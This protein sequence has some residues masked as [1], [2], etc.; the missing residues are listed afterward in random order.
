MALLGWGGVGG[1][2]GQTSSDGLGQGAA[3][4]AQERPAYQLLTDLIA[5]NPVKEE[6]A[7][8][9]VNPAGFREYVA[10]VREVWQRYEREHLQPIREWA[11]QELRAE[12]AATVFYPFSGP[13]LANML[14]FFPDART[15]VMLALE[16]VGS[17]PVL[18]PGANEPFYQSL[19]YAL[20]ELLHFN[21][22]MTEHL[23]NDLRQRE[24]DGVLPL[25]LFF[26]G[27]EQV[28]V[29]EVSFLRQAPAG[30]MLAQPARPGENFLGPGVPGVKIVFQRGP[31]APAQTL[32]Y[33]SFNLQNASWR[34]SPQF[35]AWL[36]SLGPL[37]TMVKAASYLMFKSLYSD[38][39]QFILDRSQLVLQTDEGI[40]V[41]YFDAGLWDRRLYG[42][43]QQPIALFRN[44]YQP[45]LAALYRQQ[46]TPPLP[47]GIGYHHRRHSANLLV[48]RRLPR[49]VEEKVE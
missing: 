43:Y 38:I 2:W 21:F 35:I 27:R 25:L 3:A 36:Q 11:A 1:A 20:H 9:Y 31:A 8:V 39:R 48:A 47:F 13:D 42:V 12:A 24:L 5:G 19:E 41:R 7:A 23:A 32:Y 28:Q 4:L 29:Q 18:R 44:C 6:E 14:A 15:S 45:D 30:E 17:L 33:F 46:A 10:D 16:P 34:R 49:L 22:F 40:P 37:Q 26:L